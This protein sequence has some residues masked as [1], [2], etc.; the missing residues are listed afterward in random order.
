MH[1]LLPSQ[2][3]ELVSAHPTEKRSSDGGKKKKGSHF[4][5]EGRR[6]FFAGGRRGGE[7]FARACRWLRRGRGKEGW[8]VPCH[9]EGRNKICPITPRPNSYWAQG[10]KK[11]EVASSYIRHPKKKKKNGNRFSPRKGERGSSSQIVRKK[12]K[13][14]V[15]T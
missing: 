15:S 9:G 8:F 7:A 12:R 1:S 10:K 4:V 11:E 2:R 13:G 5:S 3:R 14:A 6:T